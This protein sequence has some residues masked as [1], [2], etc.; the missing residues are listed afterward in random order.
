MVIKA[1]TTKRKVV[2]SSSPVS[3]TPKSFSTAALD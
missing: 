2:E 1:V 3:S